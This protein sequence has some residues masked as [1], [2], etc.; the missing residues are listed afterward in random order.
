MVL[1]AL[2]SRRCC[3]P[4]PCSLPLQP[5]RVTLVSIAAGSAVFDTRIIDDG[6]DVSANDA[7]STLAAVSTSSA[8]NVTCVPPAHSPSCSAE[9][10]K[11]DYAITHRYECGQPAAVACTVKV[12]DVEIVRRTESPSEQPTHMPTVPSG[13]PTV[14]PTRR[15]T[16]GDDAFSACALHAE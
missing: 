7:A 9:A 2:A 5:A 4:T 11:G 16:T 13:F 14:A 1:S 6:S 3:A 15:P 12:L 10:V 8:L